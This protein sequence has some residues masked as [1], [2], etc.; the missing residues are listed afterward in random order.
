MRTSLNF[1][2]VAVNKR[3]TEVL[4]TLLNRILSRI[5]RTYAAAKP[6]DPLNLS[7]SYTFPKLPLSHT[8]RST[9]T[10][11]CSNSAFSIGATHGGNALGAW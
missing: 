4:D 11:N 7:N 2:P 6:V 10:T 9:S 1:C 8:S 5:C 3:S